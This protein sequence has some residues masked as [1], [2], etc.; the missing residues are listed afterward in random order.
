[1]LTPPFSPQ[2]LLEKQPTSV[3]VTQHSPWVSGIQVQCWPLQVSVAIAV[4]RL[5]DGGVGLLKHPLLAGDAGVTRV[6]EHLPLCGV[7]VDTAVTDVVV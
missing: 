2:T 7:A 4:E 5:Q 1:M 3:L 6:H